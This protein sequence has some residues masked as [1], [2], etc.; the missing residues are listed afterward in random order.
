VAE[1]DPTPD[2]GTL[3]GRLFYLYEAGLYSGHQ[4]WLRA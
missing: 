1:L 3:S 4:W 2:T